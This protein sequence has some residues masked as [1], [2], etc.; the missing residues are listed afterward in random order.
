MGKKKEK[1]SWRAGAP[2]FDIA[3]RPERVDILG[4]SSEPISTDDTLLA[5]TVIDVAVLGAERL[6]SIS[7]SSGHRFLIVEQG[8]STSLQAK[9]SVT[10]RVKA[11]DWIVLPRVCALHHQR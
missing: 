1:T 9:T 10:I 11:N 8:R 6:V 7:L 4:E 5:G 2:D 3:I